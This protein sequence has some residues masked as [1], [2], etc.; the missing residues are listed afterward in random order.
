MSM[1]HLT[2]APCLV[3]AVALT[4]GLSSTTIAQDDTPPKSAAHSMQDAF[5]RV[6]ERLAPCVASIAVYVEDAESEPTGDGADDEGWLVGATDG[7]YPGYRRIA[8]TSGFCIDEENA[9]LVTARSP[10]LKDDGTFADAFDIETSDKL[11]AL[12]VVVGAEPTLD[13]AFLRIVVPVDGRMPRLLEIEWGESG[14]MKPGHWSLAVGDPF[15]IE[16]FLAPGLLS[17]TPSRDCYQ[18]KLSAS[19][20]QAAMPMHPEAFGGPLVDLEGRVIGLLAPRDRSV[21]IGPARGDLQFALPSDIIK[22]I[23]PSILEQGSARSPWVGFAVMSRGELRAALG[24]RALSRMTRPPIGIYI[25]NVFEPSPAHDAGIRPGDFLVEFD[26][27]QVNTPIEFQKW[28]YLAG[29]GAT[30]D[31]TLFRN[32]ETFQAELEILERPLEA[33]TN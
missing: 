11:H 22:G 6:A 33:V 26:G 2:H 28:F 25:E 8:A 19:Y 24:P 30:V 29:I 15:G 18:E 9:I 20:L 23:A 16:R 27:H 7:R 17:A 12:A 13:L 3:A 21:T 14:S 4:A 32:G 31:A 1:T 10:L 5:A